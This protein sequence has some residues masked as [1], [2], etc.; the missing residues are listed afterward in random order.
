MTNHSG[1]PSFNPDILDYN[2][3]KTW[4]TQCA[5]SFDTYE[6]DKGKVLSVESRIRRAGAALQAPSAAQWWHEKRTVLLAIPSWEKF[7]EVMVRRFVPATWQ[8]EAFD[9]YYSTYQEKDLETLPQG[10]G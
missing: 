8:M 1:P 5:D 6:E 2:A 3:I 9:A 7:V 4:S 10:R